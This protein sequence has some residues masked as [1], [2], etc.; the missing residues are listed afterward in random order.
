MK[1]RYI[2]EFT[3]NKDFEPGCCLDCPLVTWVYCDDGDDYLKCSL[4]VTYDEEC[5]LKEVKE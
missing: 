1:F 5:P 3:A 4:G 2:Y